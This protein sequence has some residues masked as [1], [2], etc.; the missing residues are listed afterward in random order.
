M[1]VIRL[2][3]TWNVWRKLD[4]FCIPKMLRSVLTSSVT[5]L[6][7]TLPQTV[8]KRSPVVKLDSRSNFF[9][10]CI[11][12]RNSS[13]PSNNLNLNSKFETCKCQILHRVNLVYSLH[14]AVYLEVCKLYWKMSS[15][16]W[17]RVVSLLYQVA[18]THSYKYIQI[19]F[20]YTT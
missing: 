14:L 6:P 2:L 11:A 16:Q 4:K 10:L 1:M 17:C 7:R 15:C 9:T 3:I 13:G 18:P 8:E 20:S 12:G 5:Q 19:W